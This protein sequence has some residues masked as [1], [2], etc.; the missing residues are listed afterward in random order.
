M[1]GRI[2]APQGE[3]YA[4][5]T[6]ILDTL[7]AAAAEGQA[8]LLSAGIA[9]LL[10]MTDRAE[11]SEH[12]AVA[13][14]HLAFGLAVLGSYRLNC[15]DNGA[16]LRAVKTGWEVLESSNT[17]RAAL[18]LQHRPA[19]LARTALLGVLAALKARG[20]DDL[21]DA[22]LTPHE[23]LSTWLAL[24]QRVKDKLRHVS[25]GDQVYVSLIEA[26]RFC[27]VHVCCSTWRWNRPVASVVVDEWNSWRDWLPGPPALSA[28]PGHW[29]DV[30][31]PAHPW[32]WE[33]EICKAWHAR[34]DRGYRLTAADFDVLAA[35]FH[36]ALVKMNE[37][38]FYVAACARCVG[39][40]RAQ[41]G[42]TPRLLTGRAS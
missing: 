14:N 29:R 26:Q 18:G 15:G 21:K 23:V 16:A 39:A 19:S 17:K 32:W 30:P 8:S 27:G 3:Y 9:D 40:M 35:G 33:F 2:E 24:G 36:A 20:G 34:R 7:R 13:V 31:P 42:A 4:A 28:E 10:A 5:L 37:P 38:S 12:E 6:S 25:S 41:L 1:D 11:T 22:V